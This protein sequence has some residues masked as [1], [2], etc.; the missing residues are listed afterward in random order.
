MKVRKPD[1]LHPWGPAR[2]PLEQRAGAVVVVLAD[3]LIPLD[4]DVDSSTRATA[5]ATE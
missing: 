2:K 3:G 5:S 4:L 1:R